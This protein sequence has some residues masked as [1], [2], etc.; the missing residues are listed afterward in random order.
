MSTIVIIILVILVLAAVGF[1]FF[2]YSTSGQSSF[3]QANGSVATGAQKF[4]K[5]GTPWSA[6]VPMSCTGTLDCSSYKTMG[7]CVTHCTSWGEVAGV[8]SCDG[9]PKKEYACD[10]Q[11]TEAS[12]N[13]LS[14]HGCKWE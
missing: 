9:P 6:A 11:K 4:S 13:A 10:A 12:C 5:L 1:I 3:T 14:A 2:A 7:D 8:G